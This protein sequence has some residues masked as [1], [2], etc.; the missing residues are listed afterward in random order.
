MNSK[1]SYIITGTRKG[2]G[3]QLADYYLAQGHKVAGC[4]RGVSTI[5]H[6][7]YM[8]FELDVA[9]EKAVIFMVRSVR[10]AFG[11]ID[12][13]LNNAGIAAM[14]HILTTSYKNVRMVFDTNFF[15]TF[16]SATIRH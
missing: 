6:A 10:K 3:K 14:N 8:H 7:N 13:L 12:F 15:G 11:I 9:D 5:Q 4:S 2:L 16:L 1:K